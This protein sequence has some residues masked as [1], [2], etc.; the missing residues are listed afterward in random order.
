[1][2]PLISILIPTRNRPELAELAIEAA[3]EASDED[4]EV[5]VADNGDAPLRIPASNRRLRHLRPEGVLSMPENWERA[6][7]AAR[8]EWVMLLA[9][10]YVLVP[11][12][13]E[14]LRSL[15]T[16]QTEAVTYAYGVLRQQLNPE[17]DCRTDSLRRAGGHLTWPAG[18]GNVCM[19]DAKPSLASI[20]AT[21]RYPR[22]CPMLYTALV[23]RSLLERAAR[24]TGVFFVGPAP[25]VCSALQIL[26]ESDAYVETEWP[27]V[28]LQYPSDDARWS[29]GALVPGVGL[30]ER[31]WS[32]LAEF[33]ASPLGPDGLPP[34]S[35][36]VVMATLLEFR[37]RRPE[38]GDLVQP[39]WEEF[40][41]RASREIESHP[42]GRRPGLHAQL[43]RCS[44]R[45]RFRPHVA[46]LQARA[47]LATHLPRSLLSSLLR[48]RRRLFPSSGSAEETPPLASRDFATRGEALAHL[49][50]L[51]G[52]AAPV[53]ATGPPDGSGAGSWR[54]V[55]LPPV[56]AS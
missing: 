39:S 6:L 12:G 37:R 36:A 40:V 31:F 7:R 52:G 32:F 2:V 48:V 43:L 20:Y 23:R 45:G 14:L 28:M 46:Y 49:S 56:K 54:P 29:N 33:H 15:A 21:A 51:L 11:R 38:L 25:D 35:H 8:G 5:V 10:K 55:S 19:R 44:Q 42:L 18:V 47:A 34:L 22:D 26:A 27:V 30:G 1:M 24:R 3:L 13:V 17:N 53:R 4:C 9:D 41:K 16:P 50:H